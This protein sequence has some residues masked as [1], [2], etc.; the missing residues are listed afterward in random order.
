MYI[1]D[2]PIQDMLP[3]SPSP[4][5]Q[6]ALTCVA[7]GAAGASEWVFALDV[8]ARPKEEVE[9]QCTEDGA[10]LA[11]EPVRGLLAAMAGQDIAV[12][13]Q[14][15][16]ML[17]WHRLN[18]YCGVCGSPMRP[19][20]AGGRRACSSC[21]NRAYPRVDPVV[22]ALVYDPIHDRCLLGRQ[23]VYR[24]GMFSCLAGYGEQCE[25]L[26]EAVRR[27]VKEESGVDV[28]KVNQIRHDSDFHACISYK[29]PQQQED[30]RPTNPPPTDEQVVYHSSQPWP[31]GRGSSCQLMCGFV[32]EAESTDI[33]MDSDELEDLRWFSREEVAAAKELVVTPLSSQGHAND[34]EGALSIP[35]PYAIA[36]HLIRH[37]LQMPPRH[38]L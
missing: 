28:G 32:C 2:H 26:E 9:A 34:A 27:E 21:R 14:G 11:F 13:G 4:A 7:L 24:P 22:I 38:R 17:A 29:D 6:H 10:R 31:I 8:S 37:W 16:A 18:L 3:K 12:C 23:R 25:S 1:I 20:E 36:H 19:V 5:H 15:A 33:H 30:S 35:G